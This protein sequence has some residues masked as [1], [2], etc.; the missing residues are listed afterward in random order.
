[1]PKGVFPR[2]PK[3]PIAYYFKYALVCDG[4]WDWCG[5]VP[6]GRG[7]ATINGLTEL[8]SR[9]TFK[10]WIGEIPD[11]MLVCHHCDNPLCVRPDHLFLGT[12]KDN[13]QDMANKGRSALQRYPDL[14]LGERNP[15]AKLTWDEVSA[16]RSERPGGG[17]I[18]ALAEKY[19]VSLV[20]IE[21][22]R[23]NKTWTRRPDC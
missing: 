19:G 11:G 14:T 17:R 8:A 5:N 6:D 18:K 15:S 16:I 21:K 22:I 1:M 3:D 20:A 23:S 2:K 10:L 7:R 4:C 13:S 12:H 9:F